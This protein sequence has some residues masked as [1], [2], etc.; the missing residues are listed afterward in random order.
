[1]GMFDSIRIKKELPLPEELKPL[2]ID[3]TE[4]E[5][6][7]KDLENCLLNYWISENGEL[8]DHVVEREYIP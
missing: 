3:W 1:M 7:T 2:N 6:Q 8:F 5:F 4:Q